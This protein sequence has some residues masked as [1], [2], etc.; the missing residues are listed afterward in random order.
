MFFL[1]YFIVF[2]RF[3]RPSE[4]ALLSSF[5]AWGACGVSALNT[6]RELVGIVTS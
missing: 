5:S 4:M 6:F 3:V 1:L 2:Y